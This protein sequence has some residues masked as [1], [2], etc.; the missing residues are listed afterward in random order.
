MT[1]TI[2]GRPAA[3]CAA[4]TGALCAAPAILLLAGCAG[5]L[6]GPLPPLNRPTEAATVSVFR[7]LALAGIIGP[8]T[9]S[10]DSCPTF[11]VW[12]NQEYSFQLDPGQY[13]IDYN[14]GFNECR[15]VAYIEPR[16]SYRFRLTPNCD[17]FDDGC[18]TGI[19]V[20]P[21][22]PLAPQGGAGGASTRSDCAG[23]DLGC[24]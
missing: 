20:S 8:I 14:I 22:V 3:S 23:F 13:L 10:I 15:R 11:R 19:D 7:E 12:S 2:V 4:P 18:G 1:A 24:E 6:I 5:G 9:L 17:R 21:P 16:R